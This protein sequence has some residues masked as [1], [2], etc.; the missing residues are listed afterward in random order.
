[1]AGDL[2][3]HLFWCLTLGQLV[4]VRQSRR[5][6]WADQCSP[7]VVVLT[8][9]AYQALRILFLAGY[10][11]CGEIPETIGHIPYEIR[12]TME[13]CVSRYHDLLEQDVICEILTVPVAERN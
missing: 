2:K 7:S 6:K 4:E 10:P 11:N 5:H 3:Y 12:E 8:R 1:M 9:A 13:D